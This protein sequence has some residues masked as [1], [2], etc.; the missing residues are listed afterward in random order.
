[1]E[2]AVVAFFLLI[3]LAWYIGNRDRRRAEER[4]REEDAR[5]QAEAYR[6]LLAEVAR[7]EAERAQAHR[8][9]AE[10]AAWLLQEMERPP[11]STLLSDEQKRA[12]R[13]HYAPPVTPEP[14]EQ[15]VGETEPAPRFR[16]EPATAPVSA[17]VVGAEPAST[18]AVLLPLPQEEREP[19]EPLDS[20]VI[21]LYLGTLLIVAAGIIFATYNWGSLGAWQKLGLLIGATVAFLAAGM[22]ARRF[23]RLEQAA[24]AYLLIGALLIPANI[25][26][27]WSVFDTARDRPA[28]PLLLGAI[29]MA[30][31]YTIFSVDPGGA[32]YRY[33]AVIAGTVA[34]TSLPGAIGLDEAWGGPLLLAAIAALPAMPHRLRHLEPATDLVLRVAVIPA[35]LLGLSGAWPDFTWA[36][37]IPVT[38]LALT[39]ALIRFDRTA[40]H[41]F[42][43]VAA[44][45]PAIGTVLTAAAVLDI[46]SGTAWAVLLSAIAIAL[47]AIAIRV[48]AVSSRPLLRRVLA[49]EAMFGHACAILAAAVF[50]DAWVIGVVALTGT[51]GMLWIAI[52]RRHWLWTVPADL[53]LGAAYVALPAILDL[54]EADAVS[55]YRFVAGFVVLLAVVA[56]VLDH[57][58]RT[59][60]EDDWSPGMPTWVV[61]GVTAGLLVAWQSGTWDEDDNAARLT[62][63]GT[64]LLFAGLG[65]VAAWSTRESWARAAAGVFGLA[66]ILAVAATSGLVVA[67]GVTL[68]MA[69]SLLA[70][71]GTPL[72][73]RLPEPAWEQVVFGAA[74][75]LGIAIM[76]VQALGYIVGADITVGT[77]VRWTWIGHLAVF[78][79]LAAGGAVLSLL[80]A[81][82]PGTAQRYLPGWTLGYGLL[83]LA[84]DIRLFDPAVLTWTWL[85]IGI[86]GALTLAGAT[87]ATSPYLRD[88]SFLGQVAGLALGA[89]AIACNLALALDP[90]TGHDGI[91]AAIYGTLAVVCLVAG[92]RGLGLPA[93]LGRSLPEMTLA[94]GLVATAFATRMTDPTPL[95]WSW[96]GIGIGAALA[97]GGMVRHPHPYVGR[98]AVRCQQVGLI[99]AAGA[100]VTNLAM[101]LGTDPGHEGVQAAIYGT[102][103]VLALAFARHPLAVYA[104]FAALAVATLF[105]GRAFGMA[106]DRTGLVLAGIAWFVYGTGQALPDRVRFAWQ[107]RHWRLAAIGLGGFAIAVIALNVPGDLRTRHETAIVLAIASL[108]GLAGIEAWLRR[109]RAWG[110]LPSALVMLALLLAIAFRDIGNVNAYTVPLAAYFLALGWANRHTPTLRDSLF[111]AGCALL[112]VP[113]LL[114]AL[115]ESSFRWLLVALGESVMLAVAGAAL[116]FRVWIAAGVTGVSLIVLRLLVDA[117]NALP[118]WLT[119]LIVGV[120]LL[121]AGTLRITFRDEL[122][123]GLRTLRARWR[124]M[125]ARS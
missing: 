102:L 58:Y 99:L 78:A 54:P 74:A 24:E 47:G 67:D 43:P 84:L 48:R 52:E 55:G 53:F 114:L 110:L 37:I 6:P 19:R 7:R 66:A 108:A 44:T 30:V 34:V 81:P 124:E 72:L 49:F 105:G 14:A 59:R 38:L 25:I 77:S 29:A 3:G 83:S 71:G 76:V 100:I 93:G 88:L 5:A 94:F 101:F 51:V 39:L 65:Y 21:L 69:L 26:A 41:D 28:L 56:L 82:M 121:G 119:L 96:L 16:R 46:S 12:I 104:G 98:L 111:A 20:A 79:G 73:R 97:I 118:G 91:H 109:D 32:L 64:A 106:V 60:T 95:T 68:V 8:P 4:A 50:A 90:D 2:I 70:L 107:R 87:R 11:L 9:P 86:G 122:E 63:I 33:G 27:A 120:L 15:P 36:W 92:V 113:A 22:G 10:G 31:V 75:G 42:W 80:A 112:V 116:R 1:M 61:A 18:G 85:G 13:Q 123:S 115:S 89:I 23:P 45:F 125:G 103:A 62:L 40:T 17:A 57:V 35:T 117:A